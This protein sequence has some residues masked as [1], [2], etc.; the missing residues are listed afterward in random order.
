MPF[1]QLL[2][3]TLKWDPPQGGS[4]PSLP[5]RWYGIYCSSVTVL[6]L[7]GIY[8]CM[9]AFHLAGCIYFC[10]PTILFYHKFFESWLFWQGIDC[11]TTCMPHLCW[12]TLTNAMNVF[13]V[14]QK[15]PFL[16]LI[17]WNYFIH[18]VWK[19]L[20]KIMFIRYHSL[21]L[22]H[23]L[24]RQ[25]YRL[26]VCLSVHLSPF[27]EGQKWPGGRSRVCSKCFCSLFS[28]GCVP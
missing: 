10:F 28:Q 16:N 15:A 8:C 5:E 4:I 19:L 24:T 1:G 18:K 13:Q 26:S 22:G 17:A 3:T 9:F 7:T 12:L 6:F 25:G 21:F 14:S 20:V 11:I 2:C 27:T 23:V